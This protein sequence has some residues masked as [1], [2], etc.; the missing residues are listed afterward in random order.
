[1]PPKPKSP[2]NTK[3]VNKSQRGM[4]LLWGKGF[5]PGSILI[6]SSRKVVR[7]GRSL[8]GDGLRLDDVFDV[9]QFKANFVEFNVGQ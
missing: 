6:F 3:P 1:M 2:T 8:L 4:S 5:D 9:L 7:K